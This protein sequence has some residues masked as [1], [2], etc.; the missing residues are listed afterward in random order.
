MARYTKIAC[1]ILAVA[2]ALVVGSAPAASAQARLE[3]EAF[4]WA[5]RIPEGRWINVRNLRGNVEVTR[6][7]GDKVEVIA[8]R[9]TRRGDPDYVRFEVRKY[10]S[11]DENVLICALWGENSDC[12][13]DRYRTRS[14]DRRAR[15]NDV[16]VD[17]SI[18][19]PRGVRVSAHTTNGNVRVEDAAAEV[20]AESVNGNVTVTT[21]E[22]P[23][24]AR[25][26]NGHVRA[27]MG[28]F[29]ARSDMRFATVNGSVI[30][31]FTGEIDADIELTSLNGRFATDF[32]VTITGRIDP[33][34]LRATLG[35]G[36]PRIRLS[37]VNGNVELRKR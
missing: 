3:R 17:F 23:V 2:A 33:R 28:K 21:A 35:K 30:V 25:T 32:P 4:T 34:R 31:E 7:A 13:E 9:R 10:G 24:N 15:E 26:T 11:G 18:R 29:D 20:D 19:V 16:T 1:A 37:T 5:G 27:T 12:S 14:S 22:G 36:G 6:G 8:T